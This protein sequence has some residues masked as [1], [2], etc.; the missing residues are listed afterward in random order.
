MRTNL[1]TT[2]LLTIACLPPLGASE[3]TKGPHDVAKQSAVEYW[4][5]PVPHEIPM[6]KDRK[7]REGPRYR[8]NMDVYRP[9]DLEGP[10]P[11][12]VLVHGGGLGGGRPDTMKPYADIL[13]SFGYVCFAPGYTLGGGLAPAVSDTRQAI[14]AIR[15]RA[16]EFGI[17]PERIALWGFSAGGWIGSVIATV[18]DGGSIRKREKDAQGRRTWV[19]YSTD[20]GPLS[21]K[22]SSKPEAVILSSGDKLGRYV[23][24]IDATD[25]PILSYCGEKE[26]RKRKEDLV[27]AIKTA[28]LVYEYTGIQGGKHCPDLR[29]TL[30]RNGEDVRI[31]RAVLDFLAEQGLATEANPAP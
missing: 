21:G 15:L 22:I 12:V 4:T 16:D 2:C 3:L 26:Y 25:P 6:V 13:C 29:L 9:K 19:E 10:L 24:H 30:Q 5:G 11:A 17:D 20:D 8:I 7:G 23:D 14:R 31:A 27:Q 1:L 28:G 18:E